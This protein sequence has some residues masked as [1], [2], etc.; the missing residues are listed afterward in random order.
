[1]LLVGERVNARYREPELLR[2]FNKA[3]V[4]GDK[5]IDL[6]EFLLMQVTAQSEAAAARA[7]A[8]G[9]DAAAMMEGVHLDP[10]MMMP[11][12]ALV[13]AERGGASGEEDG[14]YSGRYSEA[15]EGRYS[16]RSYGSQPS[17]DNQSAGYEEQDPYDE[18]YLTGRDGY[19]YEESDGYEEG[20]GYDGGSY[21]SGEEA[22]PSGE[23]YEEASGGYEEDQGGYGDGGYGEGGS[24]AS[25]ARDGYEEEEQYE[26]GGQYSDAYREA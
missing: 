18:A 12:P 23:A 21:L 22:Y 17:A 1:M 11:S 14:L 6:N 20:D 9:G 26:Q 24:Y 4:N 7:A 15:G 25:Q 10:R 3:D 16:A 5:L 13:A 8:E 2:M 19:G